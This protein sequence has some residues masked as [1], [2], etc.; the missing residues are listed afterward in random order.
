MYEEVVNQKMILASVNSDV[1]F[2]HHAK[3]LT[4]VA[5]AQTYH[6]M[7]GLLMRRE[8]IVLLR[9]DLA[10]P[11]TLLR[12][13]LAFNLLA[14]GLPGQCQLHRQD[15]R[16]NTMKKLKTW[17]EDFET[18][19]RSISD[20]ERQA[21]DSSPGYPPMMYKGFERTHYLL[22]GKW[23]SKRDHG[24]DEPPRGEQRDLE[25]LC[26]DESRRDV[27]NTPMPMER[28]TRR[29]IPH[30]QGGQGTRRSQRVL[31]YQP[32]GGEGGSN[33]QERPH[34]TQKCLLG[35]ARRGTLDSTYLSPN[36]SG[37]VPQSKQLQRTLNRGIK[38][39]RRGGAWG[40]LLKDAQNGAAVYENS[41]P[42]QGMYVLV[43]LGVVNLRSVNLIYCYDHRFYAIHMIFLSWGWLALHASILSKDVR[44]PNML[45]NAVVKGIILTD[46]ERA[47]LLERPWRPLAQPVPNRC[48]RRPE[49]RD[50]V[51]K[52]IKQ[53]NSRQVHL[54][55]TQKPET[56]GS[57]LKKQ[58]SS[59]RRQTAV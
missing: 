31:A 15:E 12:P 55:Y 25:K 47:L 20:D 30:A 10:E 34:C 9:V 29:A 52:A 59:Q 28:E 50:S 8:P 3:R 33:N 4:V 7:C 37:R 51:C 48:R 38:R 13:I 54:E 21:T 36:R 42:I 16:N 24:R 58:F 5:I 19:P 40:V 1:R 6:Y 2:Q 35:L 39:L 57:A 14:V 49:A 27:P 53:R 43:L 41:H 11:E 23:R 22:Q 56:M 18:T 17:L 44:T 45:S 32:G 26:N 46:F